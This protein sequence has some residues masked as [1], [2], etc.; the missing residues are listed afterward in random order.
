MRRIGGT[1]VSECPTCGWPDSDV[2]E[3]LSRH[4]TSEG[5]VTYSRCVCGEVRVRLR[6]YASERIL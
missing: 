1:L 5:V 6:P 4:F 2:H 3:V